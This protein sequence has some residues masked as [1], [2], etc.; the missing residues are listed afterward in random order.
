MGASSGGRG[1]R[2]GR[3][4]KRG[5]A[6]KTKFKMIALGEGNTDRIFFIPLI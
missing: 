1:G 3:G 2:G 5:G 4:R 6:A